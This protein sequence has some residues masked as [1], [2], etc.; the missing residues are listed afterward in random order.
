MKKIAMRLDKAALWIAG[1]CLELV[2]FLPYII[3]GKKSVFVWHDQMDENILSYVIT[4]R[5]F[6][7]HLKIFPEMMGG[8]SASSFQPYSFGLSFLYIFFDPFIAFVI[9]YAIIFAMAFGGMYFLV[10]DVGKSSI[11]ALLCAGCFSMLPFYPVYGAAVA[12]IPLVLL[13]IKFLA[14][15]KKIVLSFFL[16]LLFVLTSHLA[17]TG[18]CI[19]FLWA[20]Y[21]LIRFIKKKINRYEIIGY[22]GMIFAYAA[23]NFEIIS[24]VLFHNDSYQ[25][26]REEFAFAGTPFWESFKRIFINSSQ[27]ADSFHKYLILPVVIMLAVGVILHIRGKLTS[28]KSKLLIIGIVL[29]FAIIG[30]CL[31]FS[32]GNIDLVTDWKNKQAGALKSF[33]F[34]RFYWLLPAL[35]VFL[36]GIAA[37]VLWDMSKHALIQITVIVLILYPTI[38][39]VR[40]NSPFYMSVNQ[41][42][43]GS[44]VTGYIP[45][46]SYYSEDVMENIE[47]A[48][49]RDMNQYRVGHIGICPVM[50]LMHGF[51]TV[52][53]YSGS[54]SLEYK[55]K[56]RE[57]IA[58]DL[59]TNAVMKA[60]FDDWGSRCYLFN[61]KIGCAFMLGKESKIVL[62]DLHYNWEK[63]KELGCDYIF[64]CGKIDDY[65]RYN[66]EFIGEF[67]S[68]T[69]YWDIWV[70]EIPNF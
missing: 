4:A 33:Q 19:I 60:Y 40:N 44:S 34:V 17:F 53:G 37:C 36:F 62:N 21:L 22:G 29:F 50:A 69:S 38:I 58:D 55:H 30:I 6:G 39:L 8:Q 61:D 45:W 20:V 59:E 70:Y 35:W 26:H 1:F 57:I 16:L 47:K 68:D 7:E 15:K 14:D 43:N 63:L 12:G 3:M 31:L 10:K 11:I 9:S 56:F 52:D 41:M 24:D 67:T 49:G 42:N 46:E 5:H 66:L 18:Y 27:H 48:I 13:A 51:Y 65:Q 32:F 64:S 23:I 2:V 28:E 25:S 54:Y